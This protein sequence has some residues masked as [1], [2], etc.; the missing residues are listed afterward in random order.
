MNQTPIWQLPKSERE[1]V[2]RW[3]KTIRFQIQD[4]TDKIQSLK[5]TISMHEFYQKSFET[6]LTLLEE[7]FKFD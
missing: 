2:E 7:Q 4:Q 1:R 5:N 3:R 6:Q